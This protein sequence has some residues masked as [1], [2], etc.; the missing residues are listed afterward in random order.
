LRR[1]LV[2]FLVRDPYGR[3][4]GPKTGRKFEIFNELGI[5]LFILYSIFKHT[6]LF[7]RMGVSFFLF[8]GKCFI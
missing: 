5:S 2:L 6:G 7:L 4:V 8:G 3:A 1:L